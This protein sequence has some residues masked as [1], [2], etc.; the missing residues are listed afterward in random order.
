MWMASMP[1]ICSLNFFKHIFSPFPSFLDWHGI[2]WFVIRIDFAVRFNKSIFCRQKRQ[3]RCTTFQALL[4]LTEFK[5]IVRI[6]HNRS[7]DD[8]HSEFPTNCPVNLNRTGADDL[9]KRVYSGVLWPLCGFQSAPR[10]RQAF[11]TSLK[12]E[13]R[14][15]NNWTCSVSPAACGTNSVL[16]STAPSVPAMPWP[17][18]VLTYWCIPLNGDSN[19]FW[20]SHFNWMFSI[21]TLMMTQLL[22]QAEFDLFES[23]NLSEN[24]DLIHRMRVGPIFYSFNLL[25]RR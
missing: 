20:R 12:C 2:Q 22:Y 9:Q 5:I 16:W 25:W 13:N 11:K 1:V 19:N 14:S 10:P 4:E 3:L 17:I 18:A 15:N 6:S 23:R 8:W 7:F 24:Y 21:S